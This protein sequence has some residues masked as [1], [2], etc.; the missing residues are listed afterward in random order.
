MCAFTLFYYCKDMMNM[1]V[2]FETHSS[3][4]LKQGNIHSKL[5]TNQLNKSNLNNPF[6]FLYLYKMIFNVDLK[7]EFLMF[8]YTTCHLNQM[9][10]TKNSI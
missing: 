1:S 2:I 4:Y 6:A 7:A 9:T 5:I 8:K 10:T 3:C